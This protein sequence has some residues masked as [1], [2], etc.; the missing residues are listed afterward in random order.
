MG[1]ITEH[2]LERDG[3]RCLLRLVVE[4]SA[5]LDVLTDDNTLRHCRALLSEVRD[6]L[7]EH[8]LG[9]FGPFT[10]T[11]SLTAGS[12]SATIMVDGPELEY[13]FRGGQ[14]AGIYVDAQELAIV[15]SGHLA[16]AEAAPSA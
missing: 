11:L 10:A 1:R 15:L 8:P 14:A 16:S 9:S 12:Q 13:A 2:Y 5:V 3:A 4:G 6:G 7:L